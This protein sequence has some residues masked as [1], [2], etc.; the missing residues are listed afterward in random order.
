MMNDDNTH[1]NTNKRIKIWQQNLGKSNIVQQEPI[2]AAMPSEWDILAIQEPW[3]DHLGKTRANLKWSVVYPTM[4]GH[5]N[6]PPP[7]SVILVNTKFPSE[8]I[9]QIPIK[10]N[11]ITA[12]RVHTQ[13]HILTII[14]IYNANKHNDTLSTL[15]DAW[16]TRE[17]DFIPTMST[18]LILLGDFNRHHPTWEG[19]M[20]EH[21]TSPNRLL[22][23]LLE[24]IINMRLEM[25]LHKGIPTLEARHG[26][27]WTRPDNV[28]RTANVPS[29]ILSCKVQS[30]LC[31]A[32]TDH[33]PIVTTLDLRYYPT[34]PNACFNFKQA[35]WDKFKKSV[36][37][38]LQNLQLLNSPTFNTEQELEGV[39]N[40]LFK[41]LQD[42]TAEHVLAIKPQPHLKRWWMKTLSA[43]R[44]QK[45]K[46]SVKHFKWRGLPEHTSH[47][48]YCKIL[49]EFAK[50]INEAKANH[51]KEWIEHVSRDDLWKVNKYMSISPSD[52]SCQQ[53]PH[54]NRPNRTKTTTGNEKAKRLAEVFFPLPIDSPDNVPAFEECNPPIAPPTK[55]TTFT[56][57]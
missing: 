44:K 35:E 31:P 52:Y 29:T 11:N 5:D 54:L 38:E 47:G 57:Q 49:K 9:T 26:G 18:E 1:T 24:L 36:K 28:W 19:D 7:R 42:A 23:L 3:I 53:I 32:N 46:A 13:H 55:F 2:A 17:T 48:E 22:N 12:I 4:K 43:L 16:E 51:W 40:K 27:R 45:N 39:V 20:N 56:A 6:L 15:S 41:S 30:H 34:E 25:V 50:A 8:S 10:S 33:L 14:N 21:L 37:E